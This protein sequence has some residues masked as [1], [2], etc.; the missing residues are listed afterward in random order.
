MAEDDN[1]QLE[2]V[3]DVLANQEQLPI[4]ITT[5]EIEDDEGPQQVLIS[6]GFGVL[7]KYFKALNFKYTLPEE[8]VTQWSYLSDSQKK[9][10]FTLNKE[11]KHQMV[12]WLNA[13]FSK[14]EMTTRAKLN[15][16]NT[17]CNAKQHQ[18]GMLFVQEKRAKVYYFEGTGKRLGALTNAANELTKMQ[19]NLTHLFENQ[20][21][22]CLTLNWFMSALTF[23]KQHDSLHFA[24]SMAQLSH[25][26]AQV[27]GPEQDSGV[28]LKKL[29]SEV[30]AIA[31]GIEET[32]DPYLKY[33][34]MYREYHQLLE[35]ID[36]AW[37]KC[38][39]P[40]KSS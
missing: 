6:E 24:Q 36:I 33:I 1:L 30:S 23:I 15:A 3:K 28:A 17:F 37:K 2:L 20:H 27:V 29:C 16:I 8:A 21:A 18:E 12:C 19:V 7:D 32:I 26:I 35:E 38:G 22:K 13:T 9:V 39:S 25:E 10:F 31:R 11:G 5:L 14:D 40:Y 34:E 4:T